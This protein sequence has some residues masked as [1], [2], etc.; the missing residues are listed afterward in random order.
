MRLIMLGAPGAGKGT[1]AEVISQEYNIVTVSTG[2]MFREAIKNETEMGKLAKGFIDK[3][4]LVPDDVVVKMLSER[5]EKPDC[6]DG[7]ILDGFPRTVPQAQALDEILL[8]TKKTITK[9]IDIEVSDL[10]ITNRL[11]GR[12]VCEKCGAP[13][14]TKF[15]PTKVADI[16]DKCGGNVVLR[17][18]DEV[19]TVKSRLVA[20]HK[21]TEPLKDYYTAQNKLF[22][23][24]GQ[25]SIDETSKLCLKA[26]GDKK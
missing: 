4:Q 7:F 15:K 6:K 5:I 1:Q 8:K 22:V 18:D 24:E 25:E 9:V 14:H 21:Q 20:Y 11:S 17:K 26:V 19:E 23:V 10:A 2:N 13:Y 16:C 12:R 3:G